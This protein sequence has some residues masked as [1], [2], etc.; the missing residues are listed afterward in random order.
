MALYSSRN[1]DFAENGK[2]VMPALGSDNPTRFPHS[3]QAYLTV[4]QTFHD[5][6]CPLGGQNKVCLVGF[7]CR[8]AKNGTHHTR[9]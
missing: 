4:R 2:K 5:E 3:L 7:G 9:A 8:L 1:M 6:D